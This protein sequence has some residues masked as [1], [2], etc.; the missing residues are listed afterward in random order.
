MIETDTSVLLTSVITCLLMPVCRSTRPL[1]AL[2]V[3]LSGDHDERLL[4]V[5]DETTCPCSYQLFV[6]RHGITVGHAYCNGSPSVRI[7]FT[8][9]PAVVRALSG[10]NERFV[11]LKRSYISHCHEA[12]QQI[13]LVLK[14]ILN[15]RHHLAWPDIDCS[16]TTKRREATPS[17]TQGAR[18]WLERLHVAVFF[19]PDAQER[20]APKG[21]SM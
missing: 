14:Y 1:H 17:R 18:V 21:E 9:I 20:V 6:N 15:T 10:L 5:S 4:K 11:S 8:H 19:A 3:L 2:W 16:A 7:S 13:G 12:V